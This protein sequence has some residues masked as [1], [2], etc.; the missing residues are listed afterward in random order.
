MIFDSLVRGFRAQSDH[1]RL[2]TVEDLARYLSGG[3]DSAAGIAV[4]PTRAMQFAAVSICVKVLAESVGQL[5][6]NLMKR[7]GRKK[8]VA[9]DHSLHQLL[10]VAP[11][12]QQT[13]QEWLEWTIACLAL[14]GNAYAQINRVRG[15]V[16]ELLPFAPG[17]VTP[18]QH[19]TTRE[20]YYRV[21]FADGTVEELPADEVLHVK[22][23]GTDGLCGLSPIGHAREA[24]G[25]GIA[26]ERHGAGLFAR[27]AMPGGVLETEKTLTPEAI[28]RLR[29]SWDERH[30]GSEKAHGTAVLEDGMKWKTM[31]MPSKD[32]QWLES[33]KFQRSEIFGIYR[34]PPHMAG[35]LERATFSNIEHLSL[36]FVVHTLMP[37][38]TRI[39]KRIAL[40]LLSPEERKT[41]YPKFTVAALLRGDMKARADFYTRQLQNGALSPNE[42]RELEDLDPREGGDIFLT[43]SNMLIDGEPP[44]TKDP[45]PGAPPPAPAEDD[46]GDPP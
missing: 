5:P 15:R 1:V 36:D 14:Q 40:Q 17:S 10:N 21:G 43:P 24:V 11:N 13:N 44:P 45:K 30:A 46:E 4:T 41:Y 27:N 2:L 39:E 6:L 26:A 37:Y 35:D 18:K 31:V 32:A 33:R 8:S 19:K 16:R 22:L 38:L 28:K 12:E 23:F 29:T 42:I 20:V 25:I 7:D 34:V 3:A 9:E